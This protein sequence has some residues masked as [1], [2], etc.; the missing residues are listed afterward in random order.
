MVWELITMSAGGR[1]GAR[2][3]KLGNLALNLGKLVGTLASGTV[4]VAGITTAAPWLAFL[5]AL[6]LWDSIWSKMNLEIQEREA[7]VLWAMWATRDDKNRVPQAGLL[8][9]VNAERARHG[10]AP[11]SQAEL[12]DALATLSRMHTI[13]D[14]HPQ[15]W[16]REWVQVKFE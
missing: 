6:V 2:S 4:A 11:L 16:L 14:A 1:R 3:R 15:W 8:E 13:E 10:R 7:S 5:G 12:D 9:S